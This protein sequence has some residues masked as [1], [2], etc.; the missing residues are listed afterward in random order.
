MTSAHSQI[1]AIK[2]KPSE[3]HTDRPRRVED[4]LVQS[5][6]LPANSTEG[7]LPVR[8]LA[9]AGAEQRR[10]CSTERTLSLEGSSIL[11]LQAPAQGSFST[12]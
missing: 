3:A 11:P 1:R 4:I 6:I 2:M 10:V 5:Q 9:S 12:A 8:R 7:S